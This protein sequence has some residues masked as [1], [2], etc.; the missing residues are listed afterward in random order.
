M[1]SDVK[2]NVNIVFEMCTFI[3]EVD[4]SFFL[5]TH[6]SSTRTNI[7]PGRRYVQ[8]SGLHSELFVDNIS[9]VSAAL[10]SPD[11]YLKPLNL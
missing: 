3:L 11:L 4:C 9:P 10:Y 8:I 7:S 6:V 1:M 5:L 2:Y